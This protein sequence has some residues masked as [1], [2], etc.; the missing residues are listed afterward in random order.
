MEKLELRGVFE[1]V[2]TRGKRE[3]KK[4]EI[5][6]LSKTWKRKEKEEFRH[7]NVPKGERE[8]GEICYKAVPGMFSLRCHRHHHH[9]SSCRVRTYVTNISFF[10]QEQ[11]LPIPMSHMSYYSFQSR[12]PSNSPLS[13]SYREKNPSKSPVLYP[14]SVRRVKT[15]FLI[16]S[17]TYIGMNFLFPSAVDEFLFPFNPIPFHSLEFDS[18]NKMK[19]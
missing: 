14:L 12:R 3:R 8:R 19:K 1:L 7:P 18:F 10:F 6:L 9:R 2:Y 15:A 17:L 13:F 4:K 11:A 5:A 16:S